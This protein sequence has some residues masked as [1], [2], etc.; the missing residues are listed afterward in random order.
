MIRVLLALVM[1]ALPTIS[2][3]QQETCSGY[4]NV[5][6]N[7]AVARSTDAFSKADLGRAQRSILRAQNQ[8]RCL[9]EP[10]HPDSF[11][12]FARLRGLLAFFDQDEILATQW[13]VAA[14]QAS[15]DLAWSDL[16]DEDHPFRDLLDETEAPPLS[17]VQGGFLN[18]P[19]KGAFL[20]NGQMTWQPMTSIEVPHLIQIVDKRGSIV[21][22]MWQDGAAF[23]DTVLTDEP[24][25]SF[26]TPRW[27]QGD[28]PEVPTELLAQ[29][30]PFPT[31]KVVTSGSLLILSGT[32]YALSASR[33]RSLKDAQSSASLGSMDELAQSRGTVNL[34][35]VGSGLTGLAAVGASVTL[36][37]DNPTVGVSFRF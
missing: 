20:I 13:G 14:R 21:S 26:T 2:F 22:S 19:S 32:L 37:I 11:A 15:P 33:A 4:T 28:V 1:I 10:V 36:L 25:S 29:K 31:G 35:A 5:E 17:G 12:S 18:I 16:F 8:L 24:P 3:A 27:Y 34:L 30:R 9:D 6:L 7:E 23:S